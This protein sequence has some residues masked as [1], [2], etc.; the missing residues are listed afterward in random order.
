MRFKAIIIVRMGHF[1][2]AG[3]PTAGSVRLF[4]DLATQFSSPDVLVLLQAWNDDPVAS[5]E[6]IRQ[7]T[8][9]RK[10]PIVVLIGYSHGAGYGVVRIA[11]A[12]Q[13]RGIRTKA[14][15]LADPV[16]YGRLAPWRALIPRT[17]FQRIAIPVPSYV[18]EVHWLRQY[19]SIPRGHDLACEPGTVLHEPV[20]L[21][22]KHTQI[23]ERP[24]FHSMAL[25]VVYDAVEPIRG[26]G[27][28]LLPFPLEGA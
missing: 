3:S 18:D 9:C 13:H 21:D 11:Q 6:L 19:R 20:I 10:D 28:H 4:A 7:L 17:L 26:R 1:Q 12:L 27:P 25:R 2:Q 16:Y 22:C 14:A 5:A 8:A 24:E 23:D 15:V